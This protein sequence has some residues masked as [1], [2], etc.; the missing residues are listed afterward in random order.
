M[1]FYLTVCK[2]LIKKQEMTSKQPTQKSSKPYSNKSIQ[3][4]EFGS[5][6]SFGHTGEQSLY[7]HG[8]LFAA[9]SR[10]IL[11]KQ[12]KNY[13][14]KK[15]N[16]CLSQLFLTN[17]INFF[18]DRNFLIPKNVKLIIQ[19]QTLNSSTL[20]LFEINILTCVIL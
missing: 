15:S 19:L 5:T 13:L 9:N 17:S 20:K 10:Q 16:K 8:S 4:T 3:L 18:I 7:R 6:A 12:Y 14:E 11:S 1:P 2:F